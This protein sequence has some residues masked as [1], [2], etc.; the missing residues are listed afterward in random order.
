MYFAVVLLVIA[1]GAVILGR[2]SAA[3]LAVAAQIPSLVTVALI[4]QYSVFLWFVVGVAVA[5]QVGADALTMTVP[6]RSA[7]CMLPV[8]F[9]D[10][11]SSTSGAVAR[12][13]FKDVVSG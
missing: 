8:K 11:A 12:R 4:T 10:S 2:A 3:T 9:A 13:G 7:P 5:T 1:A 6:V